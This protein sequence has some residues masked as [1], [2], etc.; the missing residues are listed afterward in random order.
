MRNLRRNLKLWEKQSCLRSMKDERWMMWS[1]SSLIL[2][3][4]PSQRTKTTNRFISKRRF[5]QGC[6][7]LISFSDTKWR[8]LFSK[9][10]KL[11]QVKSSENFNK[12]LQVSINSKSNEM[13]PQFITTFHLERM[14]RKMTQKAWFQ[15]RELWILE[16]QGSWEGWWRKTWR[17]LWSKL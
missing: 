4:S 2:K 13:Y 9:I 10:N 15:M 1:T 14:W 11:L 7:L 3:I 6:L 17:I 16:C 5:L 8:R 12:T